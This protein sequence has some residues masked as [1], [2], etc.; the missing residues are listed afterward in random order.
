MEALWFWLA[1]MIVEAAVVF[2]GI[3][4]IVLAAWLRILWNERKGRTHD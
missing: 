4:M 1:R 3:G 2:G